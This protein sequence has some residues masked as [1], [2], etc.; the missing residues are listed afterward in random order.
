MCVDVT[1]QRKVDTVLLNGNRVSVSRVGVRS[2]QS[3][4]VTLRR[5][6]DTVLFYRVILPCYFTVLF[7]LVILPFHFFSHFVCCKQAN[8]KVG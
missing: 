7:Y 3:L 1:L 5:K 4:D 2:T 8:A 6:V